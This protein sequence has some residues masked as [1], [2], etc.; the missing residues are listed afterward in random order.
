MTESEANEKSSSSNHIEIKIA[1]Q[2]NSFEDEVSKVMSIW[3]FII[4]SYDIFRW[5]TTFTNE[6]QSIAS[7]QD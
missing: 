5:N 2:E 6:I 4:F 7:D 1:K 3:Q